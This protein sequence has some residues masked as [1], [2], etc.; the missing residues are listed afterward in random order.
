M[1]REFVMLPEF[2]RQWKIIGF[3]DKDLA[4]LQRQICINP[5]IGNVMEGTGGIR[6]M[7]FALEGR[8][9]SGSVRVVYVDFAFYKKVYLLSA[10][11]K[12][13][14]SNLTKAERNNLKNLVELLKAALR[15]E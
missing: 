14:K 15:K 1:T 11:T 3:Q 6:K 2:E 4:E 10:Y 12:D 8:G 13:E 7:R 9:K 5:Y